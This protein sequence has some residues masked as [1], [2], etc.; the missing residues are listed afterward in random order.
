MAM[1]RLLAIPARATAR[2]RPYRKTRPPPL[3]ATDITPLEAE[4]YHLVYNL[5]SLTEAEI[6]VVE[7]ARKKGA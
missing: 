2:V 5:Y 3:Q 1:A 6:A 4:I 7:G